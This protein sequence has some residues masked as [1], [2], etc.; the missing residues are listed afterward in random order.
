MAPYLRVYNLATG[1][2]VRVCPSPD[3]VRSQISLLQYELVDAVSEGLANEAALSTP[4]PSVKRESDQ[5]IKWH[6]TRLRRF[7]VLGGMPARHGKQ[8]RS[9]M[10][11]S[12]DTVQMRFDYSHA[13]PVP[14]LT[15]HCVVLLPSP[16]TPS[17]VAALHSSVK[18]GEDRRTLADGTTLLSAYQAALR[19]L[20]ERC[21]AWSLCCGGN[22][23]WSDAEQN[24]LGEPV[25]WLYLLAPRRIPLA[26]AAR[27]QMERL[28][29]QSKVLTM[30]RDELL[31]TLF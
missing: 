5:S 12:F 9:R 8:R 3:L 11:Y 16:G 26:E 29:I 6:A 17:A 28:P 13:L 14:G 30:E 22:E 1:V 4:V 10:C 24:S 27:V 23:D 2:W 20:R 15:A 7:E 21:G 18:S 25:G 31:G 19:V